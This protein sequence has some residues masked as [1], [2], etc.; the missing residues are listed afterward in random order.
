[1]QIKLRVP[2]ESLIFQLDSQQHKS[3]H[4]NRVDA[5]SVLFARIS[6]QHSS[7]RKEEMKDRRLT[8]GPNSFGNQIRSYI[9]HPYRLVNDHRTHVQHNSPEDVL[10]GEIDR[11][12]LATLEQDAAQ[13][14][15]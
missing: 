11:F 9:L 1:M 5:L 6:Q 7:L 10:N 8:L 3:Q 4:R 13:M 12:L 2:S 15:I 14:A